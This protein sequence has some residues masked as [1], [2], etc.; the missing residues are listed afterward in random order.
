MSKQPSRPKIAL[1]ATGGTIASVA[2]KAT[3]LADYKV[4]SSIEDMVS[5]VSALSDVADFACQQ[6]CN[7]ESHR[8]D[9]EILGQLVAAVQRACDD[10]SV[11]AVVVTH[12]TDTLEETAFLLQLVI[13]TD[14]PIVMVGA[15]RPASALSADGP[16]NLYHA[17]CVAVSPL[18]RG[19]GVLVVMNDRIVSARHVVKKH[20]NGVDAFSATEFGCLGLVFGQWIRF[21]NSVNCPHTSKSEFKRCDTSVSWPMVDVIYDHQG[22]GLHHFNA[23]IE[24]GARGIVLAATGQGSLSPVALEGV[25]LAERASVVVAR[26]TRVWE[27]VVRQSPKDNLFHTVAAYT[28][29]PTKARILLRLALAKGLTRDEIQSCFERY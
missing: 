7:V 1:L 20:A 15:M 29:G 16:L 4:A 27:G 25:K 26:S 28:L 11:T 21:Q 2:P 14:K 23:A 24:A 12:G 6:V 17:A 22:A 10:D 13:D 8:I 5:A 3:Q 19:Q 18:S 9:D